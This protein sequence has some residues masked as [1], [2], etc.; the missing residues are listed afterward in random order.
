MDDRKTPHRRQWLTMGLL[1]L[2]L[3][4]LQM[5]CSGRDEVSAPDDPSPAT[6]TLDLALTLRAASLDD[7]GGSPALGESLTLNIRIFEDGTTTDIFTE[8]RQIAPTSTQE[9]IRL[10]LAADADRTLRAEVRVEGSR[11]R[12]TGTTDTGLIH[13]ATSTPFQILDGADTPVAMTLDDLVPQLWMFETPGVQHELRWS[14]V[15]G[16]VQYRIRRA[17]EGAIPV[18]FVTTRFDTTLV[19]PPGFQSGGTAVQYQVQAELADG[20]TSAFSESKSATETGSVAPGDVS[21]LSTFQIAATEVVLAWTAP[22]DDGFA[23]QASR[24]DLRQSTE[25]IDAFNFENAQVVTI[26]PPSLA[27]LR[28]FAVIRELESD[29][30]YFFSIVTIDEAENRSGLSNLL[31][32]TTPLPADVAAPN[33]ITD[34]NAFSP[35]EGVIHLEWTAPTD[36][37]DGRA[38]SYELR[39]AP[40]QLT[41]GAFAAATL[42]QTNPPAAP[43]GLER[44]I[45]DDLAPGQYAFALRSRDVIGNT[46]AISNIDSAENADT[47]APDGIADLAAESLGNG[48]ARLRWS[49][50]GDNGR[51]GRAARHEVRFASFELSESNFEEATLLEAPAPGEPGTALEFELSDLRAETDYWFAARTFDEA[52]NPSGL[53]NLAQLATDD[54]EA[55]AQVA[56]LVA[57]EV[58]GTRAT[59]FWTAP[60]DNDTNGTATT[61]D[62]RF[63]FDPITD[64]NFEDASQVG[65]MPD[66]SEGGTNE[67]VSLVSS[68]PIDVYLGLITE[69]EVGNRSSLSNVIFV[70]FGDPPPN[71]PSNLSAE[72]LDESGIR[73]DWE[74]GDEEDYFEVE[75]K[76]E[77]EANFRRIGI[78]DRNG[79]R[80]AP[81][82]NDAARSVFSN[83]DFPAGTSLAIHEAQGDA[84]D[85]GRRSAAVLT[86]DVSPSG[87]ES[88][89]SRV[90]AAGGDPVSAVNRPLDERTTYAYRIRAFGPGGP[91]GYSNETTAR[92]LLAP[93]GNVKS[94]VFGTES[95]FLSWEQDQDAE[96]YIVERAT[97]GGDFVDL[98]EVGGSVRSIRD[99]EVSPRTTYD[100]RVRALAESQSALS[101]SIT[102]TVDDEN[103]VCTVEPPFIKFG[104]VDVNSSRSDFIIITNTGGGRLQGTLVSECTD[105]IV[106]DSPFDL[107]PGESAGRELAFSPSSP[108]QRKCALAISSG[109]DAVV[110]TGIGEADA[111]CGLGPAINDFGEVAVGSFKD[112]LFEVRN[113]GGGV[114]LGQPKVEGDRF[115]SFTI[116]KGE[117]AYALE[118]GERHQ[119]V[120][121]FTPQVSGRGTLEAQLDFGNA[122]CDPTTIFGT[123]PPSGACNWGVPEIDFGAVPLGES[124][125]RDWTMVN[126]G[127][128][129]LVGIMFTSQCSPQ[130]Q[131]T[132]LTPFNVGPR[133]FIT[134]TITFTPSDE[135]DYECQ[136]RSDMILGP[137]CE[138]LQI[139]GHGGDGAICA[140]NT[141]SIDF[142][143]L[144]PGVSD[145]QVVIISNE[146]DEP[147]VISSGIN[148]RCNS[149]VF[150]LLEGAGE[151]TIA[152]GA[153]G[154]IEVRFQ[155]NEG[156]QDYTCSILI[157]G[158]ECASV[159]LFASTVPAPCQVEPTSHDFGLVLV[160]QSYTKPFTITNNT[161]ETIAGRISTNCAE[162]VGFIPSQD[163]LY[164]LEPGEDHDFRFVL[165]SATL[166]S[167]RCQI[168]P[169]NTDCQ[170]SL[171]VTWNGEFART[172]CRL[173]TN[174]LTPSLE[175]GSSSTTGFTITNTGNTT[176]N[177]DVLFRGDGQDCGPFT[178][179]TGGGQ[180]SLLPGK[181]LTVKLIYAPVEEGTYLCSLLPLVDGVLLCGAVS[182]L[183]T[184][185]PPS[186]E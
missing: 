12:P 114:L 55:P 44:V 41:E 32:I 62:L 78:V 109:C 177:L 128:A 29:E 147:L 94:D 165:D 76:S 28:D 126:S 99:D 175:V 135:I 110:V 52:E 125:S 176:L 91:S 45:L 8:T 131:V 145:V 137:T 149:G 117:Q 162:N 88:V 10:D 54:F 86:A 167:N 136:L 133:E 101:D 31:T 90:S 33:Q 112:L 87:A 159:E 164:N 104:T 37:R 77:T 58:T 30:S 34:L 84:A 39:Y 15:V 70:R 83:S 154:G 113:L 61:Y 108:G 158:G 156:G 180:S 42:V 72:A 75:R 148:R 121:R 173:S 129:D 47:V 65:N 56:D 174:E 181:E 106:E 96:S 184:A 186:S 81:S 40:D 152:P 85:N 92:T 172:E 124:A 140:L 107:G 182:V 98:V 2:S 6:G 23:G 160:G 16:A 122:G 63:S 100:Y 7:A 4:T 20:T 179:A 143:T 64:E 43:G 150:E 95:V 144:N 115:Q 1:L 89:A 166:G 69:D 103:P 27:G 51:V 35:E 157:N 119:F 138:P 161:D 141:T 49:A 68:E 57:E 18:E 82:G 36:E 168:F 130:F 111:I 19:L 153:T 123:T 155:S 74:Y 102:L 132:G 11:T 53:S 13:L 21:D 97:E 71:A 3:S 50:S 116:I 169:N 120:V 59:M 9:A 26:D 38:N 134:G 46:S 14:A 170:E 127:D 22:G 142:G 25:P 60:G 80:S 66:P 118:S 73:L 105:F 79:F 48:R 163:Q 146:G 185:L 93:P 17:P 183:G 139:R 178:I 5:A 67:E 24:Y 151:Q 171:D